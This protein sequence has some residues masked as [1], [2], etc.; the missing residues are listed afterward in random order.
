[1][2]LKIVRLY[3]LPIRSFVKEK[4][5]GEMYVINNN[6]VL[7]IFKCL[8]LPFNNNEFQISC[9]PPGE[10]ECEKRYSERFKNHFHVKDVEGRTLILIHIGN[11]AKDTLGCILPG[12]NLHIESGGEVEWV[13]NSGKAMNILN[14]IMPDKFRLVIEWRN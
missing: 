2:Y 1:M 10:Y 4:T 14:D 6:M 7:N 8:E 5:I 12:I 9:I 3:Q 13:T 11:R